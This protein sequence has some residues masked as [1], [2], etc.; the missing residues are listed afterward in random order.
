M[1]EH[2]GEG[3]LVTAYTAMNFGDDLFLKMLFERYPHQRFL[4]FTA[5]GYESFFSKFPNVVPINERA[6]HPGSRTHRL[7]YK[8][9][10]IRVSMC[11]C[12][13]ALAM[14]P[15]IHKSK[16]LSQLFHC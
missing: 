8:W 11:S 10:C 15:L 16:V 13:V 3:I 9:E 7:C 2:T 6:A 4:T 5:S 1:T 12:L 14:L